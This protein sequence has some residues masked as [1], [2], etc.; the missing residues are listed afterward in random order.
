[1]EKELGL[2]T[3]FV[4]T[5][6]EKIKGVIVILGSFELNGYLISKASSLDDFDGLFESRFPI[7]YKYNSDASDVILII[8]PSAQDIL[9]S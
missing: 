5:L 7:V 6:L 8:N 4:K 3:E 1:M 9:S 2:Y